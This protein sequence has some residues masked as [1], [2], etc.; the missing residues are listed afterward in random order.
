M[1]GR[2]KTRGDRGKTLGESSIML[3]KSGGAW[4]RPRLLISTKGE[5]TCILPEVLRRWGSEVIK[6]ENL[7]L[8]SFL[9]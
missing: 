1:G 9:A 3:A 2:G 5:R 4:G 8:P 6:N 7:R